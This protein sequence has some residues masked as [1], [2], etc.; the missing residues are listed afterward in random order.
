MT[1]FQERRRL[2]REFNYIAAFL[3]LDCN[4]RC[5]YCINRPSTSCRP[6]G[7][8][9]GAGWVDFFNRFDLPD[10]LPISLQ[11][12][13]PSLHPDF[14]DIL[15]GIRED[16]HVDLL[17]NLSFDVERFAIEIPPARFLRTSPYP[18]I[19]VTYH[20]GQSDLEAL[21]TKLTYLQERGYPVGLY[22][23]RIPGHENL[24]N[25]VA[26]RSRSLGLDF[27]T[28]EFLGQWRGEVH[29]TYHY[30]QGVFSSERRKCFCRTTELLI[31]PD[32]NVFRCHRDLYL[33]ENP[34][35]NI[36]DDYQPAFIFR[37]CDKFG[38]CNPCD[39]KQKT[40]RFQIEGHA[41][42]EIHFDDVDEAS[43]PPPGEV[44][45]SP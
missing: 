33:K 13:E 20:P 24:I 14:F 27:R 34:I 1:A 32:G 45:A 42:V 41:S 7:L 31:A 25:S 29:G 38:E 10:D 40:N 11:G 9:D 16:L 35:G 28:K 2:P 43:K 22:S 44:P 4:Y 5:T 19:R 26:G 3:T 8:L 39:L 6:R 17:T 12:G 37:A 21:F 15:K 30:P 36:A 23:I 18:S